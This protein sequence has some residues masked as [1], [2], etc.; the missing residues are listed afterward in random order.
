MCLLAVPLWSSFPFY[1]YMYKFAWQPRC[2][3]TTC[4]AVVYLVQAAANNNVLKLQ[5]P[6]DAVGDNTPGRPI[7]PVTP[8]RSRSFL[9]DDN[10][11]SL[12]QLQ[13]VLKTVLL[14]GVRGLRPV[15]LQHIHVAIVFCSKSSIK[16]S[17]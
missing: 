8:P 5:T 16:S 3:P 1:R 12:G 9:F 6:A 11:V 2:L 14:I 10:F 7:I 4:R 15:D 17:E 13:L